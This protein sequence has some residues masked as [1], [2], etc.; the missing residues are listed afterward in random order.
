MQESVVLGH[1]A[2]TGLGKQLAEPTACAVAAG[3]QQASN[4]FLAIMK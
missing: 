4:G 2:G 3:G 1:L